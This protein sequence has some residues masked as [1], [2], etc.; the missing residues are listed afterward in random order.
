MPDMGVSHPVR[1]ASR[2]LSL[3]RGNPQVRWAI[4]NRSEPAGTRLVHLWDGVGDNVVEQL[5]GWLTVALYQER[6]AA[7]AR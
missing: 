2:T 7:P 5:A 4:L 1:W 6:V 3:A